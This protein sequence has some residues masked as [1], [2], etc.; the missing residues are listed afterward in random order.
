MEGRTWAIR[1]AANGTNEAN[2]D[3]WAVV[4]LN[5]P[6]DTPSPELLATLAALIDEAPDLESRTVRPHSDFFATACCGDELRA[7]VAAGAQSP[8]APPPPGLPAPLFALSGDDMSFATA[9]IPGVLW[10][11][12]RID[13]AGNVVHAYYPRSVDTESEIVASG[14]DPT[15][16]V[17]VVRQTAGQA[18][19]RADVW[20][21]KPDGSLG[22]AHQ[23]GSGDWAWHVDSLPW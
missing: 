6:G 3:Y 10:E 17:Q 15:G 7:W 5:A 11:T 22:H 21:E 9:V 13:G 1:S 23:N 19:G 16:T 4:A 20:W 14:A 8:I 12:F 2:R 18:A